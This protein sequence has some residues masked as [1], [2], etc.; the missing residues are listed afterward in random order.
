MFGQFCSSQLEKYCFK[1]STPLPI[2]SGQL[3]SDE[4]IVANCVPFFG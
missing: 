4:A 2:F 1:E 3:L